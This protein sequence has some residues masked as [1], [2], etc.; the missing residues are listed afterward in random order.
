MGGWV[1]G[2]WGATLILFLLLG[3]RK[4]SRSKLRQRRS[5]FIHSLLFRKLLLLIQDLRGGARQGR[6][7]RGCQG[8]GV[9]LIHDPEGRRLLLQEQ[10]NVR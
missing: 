2:V 9:L 5:L 6:D 10:K 4:T 1:G 7:L 8:G 3:K